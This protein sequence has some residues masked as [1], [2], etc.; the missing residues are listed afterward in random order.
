MSDE[1]GSPKFRQNDDLQFYKKMM[2]LFVAL[3]P[4]VIGIACGKSIKNESDLW[5][6]FHGFGFI[7]CVIASIGLVRGMRLK[8]AQIILGFIFP[9]FFFSLNTSIV[10]LVGCSQMGRIAP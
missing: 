7:L 8:A 6:L 2:W 9:I 3:S 5:L 10:I 4:S 1:N